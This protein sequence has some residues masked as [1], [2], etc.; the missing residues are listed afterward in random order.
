MAR[1]TWTEPALSDLDQIA[2]YVALENPSAARKLVQRVFAAVERLEQHPKSGNI[3]LELEG[4]RYRE[5]VVGPCRVFYRYS[6]GEVLVLCVIRAE[7]ELRN[8]LI[9]NRDDQGPE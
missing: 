6:S 9:A 5:A 4:G 7:R 8:F 3:P 1:L 2:E